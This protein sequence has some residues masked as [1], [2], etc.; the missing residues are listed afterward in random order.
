[1]TGKVNG[2]WKLLMWLRGSVSSW[3]KSCKAQ[4]TNSHIENIM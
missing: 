4:D 3:L 1:M 2:G